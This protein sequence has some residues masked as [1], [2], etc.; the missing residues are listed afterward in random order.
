MRIILLII[1]FFSS[2][3]SSFSQQNASYYIMDCPEF[4]IKSDSSFIY[5]EDFLS[6]RDDIGYENSIGCV[7][8]SGI[9]GFDQNRIHIE[10]KHYTKIIVFLAYIAD[11]DFGKY[12]NNDCTQCN[13]PI[14]AIEQLCE[15]YKRTKYNFEVIYAYWAIYNARLLAT[16]NTTFYSN[17]E[18]FGV[19]YFMDETDEIKEKYPNSL[20][21]RNILLEEYGEKQYELLKGILKCQINEK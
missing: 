15:F 14:N 8:F 10:N 5:M 9:N 11:M 7:G 21:A 18:Q 13:P 19:S 17:I 4:I 6:H 3:L 20:P 16:I 1:L 12:Y 2:V